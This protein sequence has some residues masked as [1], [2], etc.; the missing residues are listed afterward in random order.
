MES[1]ASPVGTAARSTGHTAASRL[2]FNTLSNFLGQ[3]T[4][5]LLTFFSTPYITR[6]M[7]S[8]QYG[9]LSLLMIYLF[10]FSLL[11]LGMNTSLV[12]YLAELLPGTK[13]NE[14]QRYVSTALTVLVGI[15]LVAGVV[16]FVAATPLVHHVFQGTGRHTTDTILALR[17]ASIAFV[18]QFLIQVVSAVPIAAQRFEVVNAVRVVSEVLRIGGTVA[19]VSVGGRLPAMLAL[20][21]FTSVFLC[22]AYAMAARRIVPQLS[23]RPGFS[24]AHLY[25]LLRHSKYVAVTNVSNQVVGT[26][27]NVILGAFLPVANL[28]YYGIAYSLCQR[29]SAMVAN[30]SSVVFPAASA[31]AASDRPDQVRELYVR[32]TKIAAATSCFPALALCLFSRQFLLHWLGAEY[33]DNGALVLSFLVLGFMVNACSM[34]AFQV[35][36]GTSYVSTAARGSVVYMLISLVLF[37]AFIPKFGLRGASAG[38]F[39]GQ[40]I[41]VLWFVGKANRILA[42]TWG[43]LV[44]RAYVRVA[45]IAVG[46]C[47]LSVLWWPW[48]H[49]LVTL[50]LAVGF[51]LAAYAA[52]AYF[53]I[54]DG[55]ERETCRMLV[56]RFTSMIK[57]RS[58]A[59][60]TAN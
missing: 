51:G 48:I 17:I 9:V 32:G 6:K 18:L 24:R 5:I 53:V 60:A 33:A 35:L 43:Q 27:D 28:A 38:F 15:G 8:V 42:V 41:F 59:A 30:V 20:V 52:M 56:Q 14:M 44:S 55:K 13:Y 39:A 25:S 1:A 40:L 7:G 31:F 23:F 11:N 16:I 49:S 50:G 34:V 26:A 58:P 10:S 47:G 29:F 46:C 2:V 57:G 45:L 21:M 4:L 12:K 54:L 19:I 36:Q 37:V 3:A 22:V